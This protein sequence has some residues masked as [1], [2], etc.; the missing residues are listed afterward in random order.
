M[1]LLRF[2]AQAIAIVLMGIP[3]FADTATVDRVFT[4][5]QTA[6]EKAGFKQIIDIDHARLAQDAGV[7]MPA[8]RVQLFMDPELTANLMATNVRVGLDLP[9]RVLAF[10]AGLETRATYT[11]SKFLQIR[12]GLPSSED[13]T[14]FDRALAPVLASIDAPFAPAPTESLVLDYGI[15]SLTSDRDFSDTIDNLKKIVNSQG[16]TIWFGEIDFTAILGA[17]A[18]SK[19]TLLLFGG[20]APGGIAMADYPSIGLDAFCQKLLVYEDKSGVVQVIYNSIVSMAD[21]HYGQHIKPH[22]ELDER[23]TATF[24]NAIHKH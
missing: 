10:D 4:T 22:Q 5:A 14:A 11:N 19:A 1:T 21:L 16:D 24:S 23:L 17:S 6:A 2:I 13:L 3:V 15:L 20:P 7:A 18:G 8:S 9:F 12:H